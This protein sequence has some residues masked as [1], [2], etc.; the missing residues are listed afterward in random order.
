MSICIQKIKVI[1]TQSMHNDS[2]WDQGQI[3]I[4]FGL[5]HVKYQTL[6][7]VQKGYLC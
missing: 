7:T 3:G 4:K 1:S 6:A 5:K 2:P